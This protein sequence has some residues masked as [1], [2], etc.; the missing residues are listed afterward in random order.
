MKAKTRTNQPV[1]YFF[2]SQ[3]D[4]TKLSG[5]FLNSLVAGDIV[6]KQ[7]GE[8]QHAYI[9]SYKEDGTGICLTY[10]D[11]SV[12]ETIS[13]DYVGSNWV[14][15]STDV[16]ELVDKDNV[17]LLSG[18]N[19]TGGIT[20][21]SIIEDMS[22]YEATAYDDE[23]IWTPIYVSACKNG[24]KL[25]FVVFGSFTCDTSKESNPRIL[26]FKV[27][28]T[29]YSKLYPYGIYQYAQVIS[30]GLAVF[31]ESVSSHKQVPFDFSKAGSNI[32]NVV[33]RSVNSILTNGSQYYFRIEATFL[34]NDNMI[35]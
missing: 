13:Y 19:F 15:N 1:Y 29:I 6:V 31:S 5:S 21:P 26:T 3:Q 10:T 11:A 32:L 8:Q 16:T 4:M 17:A 24:N 25:T 7:T 9:V 18:A 27:P 28:S 23:G 30:N 35:S 34:L 20:S 2:E 33:L 14:Y 12:V 22:G